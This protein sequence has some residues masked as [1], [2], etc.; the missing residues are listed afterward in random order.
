MSDFLQDGLEQDDGR[1]KTRRLH[2]IH[3]KETMVS[4]R[5]TEEGKYDLRQKYV[6]V[7]KDVVARRELFMSGFASSGQDG[8]DGTSADPTRDDTTI[9]IIAEVTLS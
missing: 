7:R 5:C 3:L 8:V 6:C 1:G 4:M 2:Q 9:Y